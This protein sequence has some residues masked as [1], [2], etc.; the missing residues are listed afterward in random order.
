MSPQTNSGVTGR[1]WLRAAANQSSREKMLFFRM[2]D[3]ES[4]FLL[5]YWSKIRT[6]RGYASKRKD[7]ACQ[8]RCPPCWHGYG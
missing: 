2:S 3:S 6:P 7:G 5:P 1:M 8:D 4:D